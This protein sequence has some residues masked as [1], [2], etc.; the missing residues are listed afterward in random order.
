MLQSCLKG[1]R[2]SMWSLSFIAHSVFALTVRG[3]AV[4]CAQLG[5]PIPCPLFL[6]DMFSVAENAGAAVLP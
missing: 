4:C 6:A 5:Y 3:S 2:P 1:P